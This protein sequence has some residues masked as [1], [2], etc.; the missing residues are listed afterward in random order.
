MSKPKSLQ[1]ILKQRQ[2]AG[3]VGRSE[4]VSLFRENLALPLEEDS[5]RF[6]FN[7]WGQGGVGK[8]TLLYQFIKIMIH[9]NSLR[10][11]ALPC[12]YLTYLYQQ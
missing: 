4:Q 12:P 3:F 10:G 7:V 5:R 9:T 8:S 2:Q 6:I 11:T 1:D